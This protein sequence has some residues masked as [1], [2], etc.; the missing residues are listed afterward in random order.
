MLTMTAGPDWDASS[1]RRSHPGCTT[2]QKGGNY[3]GKHKSGHHSYNQIR[4]AD[5]SGLRPGYTI[6]GKEESLR[7][8]S[9]GR[10][11]MLS[12]VMPSVIIV[13]ESNRLAD[14]IGYNW[15]DH[16]AELVDTRFIAALEA[17]SKVFGEDR[18]KY[19]IKFFMI[20]TDII[21]VFI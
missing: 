2:Y 13:F 14:N 6:I 3:E 1:H 20:T 16:F 9:R 7:R 12:P 4:P 5:R 8:E 11:V 15:F 10:T 18:Q 19:N 21:A 17:I